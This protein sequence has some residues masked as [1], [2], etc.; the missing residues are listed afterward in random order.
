[1]QLFDLFYLRV[2]QLHVSHALCVYTH[3]HIYTCIP[4][5]FGT[6]A[7]EHCICIH[8]YV[9]IHI[10]TYTHTYTCIYIHTCIYMHVSLY[11]LGQVHLDEILLDLRWHANVTAWAA[12]WR[13][14]HG[15]AFMSSAQIK[16]Q[17]CTCPEVS[18]CAPVY[19]NIYVCMHIH[20]YIYTYMH[21]LGIFCGGGESGEGV[22][23][24]GG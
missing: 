14:T 10:Y 3:I 18:S 2:K 23:V 17:V 12:V 15:A 8:T 6:S 19:M 22:N 4:V 21:S 5:Q 1:V 20:I 7:F 11:S 16:F 9:H 24:L 13:V